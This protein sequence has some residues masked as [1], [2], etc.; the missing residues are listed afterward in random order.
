MKEINN[1]SMLHQKFY[2]LNNLICKMFLVTWV[3]AFDENK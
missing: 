1:I 3:N 2:V